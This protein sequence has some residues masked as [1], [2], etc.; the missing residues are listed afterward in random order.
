MV[1]NMVVEKA[2]SFFAQRLSTLIS[3]EHHPTWYE[4]VK[5]L[6]KKYNL[7][8]VVY[9]HIPKENENVVHANTVNDFYKEHQ[10]TIKKINL[11]A[12]FKEYF[13]FPKNFPNNNFDFILV[14]GRA[15]VECAYNSIPKLK[16]GGIF[17]LDNSERERY[18]LIHERLKEWPSIHTTTG[19]TDTTLW[20]KP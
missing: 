9:H 19:L 14:D 1:W 12:D 11:K 2:Q 16:K 4:K 10:I 5:S 15:R 7:E 20:F 18:T 6:L 8:N 17:V 3:V 13:Q